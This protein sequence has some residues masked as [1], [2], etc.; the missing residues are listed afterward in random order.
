MRLVAVIGWEPV[1]PE[2][3]RVSGELGVHACLG[4]RHIAF[5]GLEGLRLELRRAET[6]D[7][8]EQEGH[9]APPDAHAGATRRG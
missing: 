4:R 2:K 1:H 6:H 7:N 3:R 5:E 9:G 8:T